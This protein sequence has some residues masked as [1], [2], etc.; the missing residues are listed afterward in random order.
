[1]SV[2]GVRES[3]VREIAPRA[4]SGLSGEGETALEATSGFS[5]DGEN[6]DEPDI[7]SSRALPLSLPCGLAGAD[8]G[9]VR[10][11]WLSLCSA[12]PRKRSGDSGT[13]AV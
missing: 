5:G 1:M 9:G 6:S 2:D 7:P 4:E 13:S 3:G 11:R 8:G 12:S 10:S